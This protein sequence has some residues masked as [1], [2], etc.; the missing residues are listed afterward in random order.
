MWATTNPEPD[1]KTG[2]VNSP[3]NTFGQYSLVKAISTTLPRDWVLLISS[4][5]S[6]YSF[7]LRHVLQLHLVQELQDLQVLALHSSASLQSEPQ[8][9]DTDPGPSFQNTSAIGG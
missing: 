9:V 8:D 4:G 3:S 7:R 2:Q 5:R 6:C 1:P